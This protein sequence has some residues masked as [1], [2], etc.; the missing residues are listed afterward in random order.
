MYNLQSSF[1]TK[2]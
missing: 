1:P 2:C